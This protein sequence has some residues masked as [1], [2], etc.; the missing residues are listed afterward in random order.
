MSHGDQSQ[1]QSCQRSQALTGG[2][3]SARD[4]EKEKKGWFHSLTRR[5]KSDSALAVSA[6]A[7]TS[8]S[9]NNN[10]EVCV[11]EAADSSMASCSNGGTGTGTLRRRR[12]KDKRNVFARLRRKVGQGLSSLRNWHSMG[13]CDDGG[14]TDATYEFLTPAIC[15][16]PTLPF[17]HDYL[18]FIRKKWLEREDAHSPNQIMYKACSEMLNQVWYWGEISRRDSQRQL[19]DKPTGSFLVRDSETSGSQFTL[20]FRIVNVTLHYRLEYR[21]NFWHFEEL[22]Y[23][24]IVEMIEDI[25]HRCTN[26]NFVCFVKVPNEMQPPFPVILKYPL[27]RYANMPKLQDLCRRVLQRQMS[28]EQLAQLPVPAQMLE[29]LSVER[30]L[31][32][33]S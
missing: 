12:D 11:L 24:S 16:E 1:N 22:K 17:T 5:K 30:E 23:E 32:F 4:R 21:D 27:S 3:D 7:S 25:L 31:V 6:S 9:Q 2:G 26:D 13:D 28:R 29:Y 20:S 18:R 14:T 8:G 15:P 10:N 33:Q 19:S